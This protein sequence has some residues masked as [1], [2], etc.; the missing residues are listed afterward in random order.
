MAKLRKRP[1]LKTT[2][3]RK[4]LLKKIHSKVVNRRKMYAAQQMEELAAI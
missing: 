1:G 3:R 2:T 4:H